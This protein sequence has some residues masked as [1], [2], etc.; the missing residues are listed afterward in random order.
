[1]PIRYDTHTHAITRSEWC[2]RLFWSHAL[3]LIEQLAG[4][5]GAIGRAEGALWMNWCSLPSQCVSIDAL[6][7]GAPVYSTQALRTQT[8][9]N[10]KYISATT[11]SCPCCCHPFHFYLHCAHFTHQVS[12]PKPEADGERNETNTAMAH[13]CVCVCSRRLCEFEQRQAAHLINHL[14]LSLR[15]TFESKNATFRAHLWCEVFL[16]LRVC[17][18]VRNKRMRAWAMRARARAF[19]IFQKQK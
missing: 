7:S 5:F 13:A 8:W 17:V 9:T 10:A 2:F 6:A 4:I 3:L 18:C 12:T 15:A 14:H 19:N 1:M 11:R 16:W